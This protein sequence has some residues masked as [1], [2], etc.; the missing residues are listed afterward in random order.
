MFGYY[1]TIFFECDKKYYNIEKKLVDYFYQMKYVR[2]EFRKSQGL[3]P[4]IGS[5]SIEIDKG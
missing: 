4:R 1:I 5:R 2:R 3:L